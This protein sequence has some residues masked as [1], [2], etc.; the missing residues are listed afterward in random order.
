MNFTLYQYKDHWM[1]ESHHFIPWSVVAP[2]KEEAMQK[3]REYVAITTGRPY[4]EY[5]I[6]FYEGGEQ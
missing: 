3:C 6:T 2:T 4:T 5:T 1:A